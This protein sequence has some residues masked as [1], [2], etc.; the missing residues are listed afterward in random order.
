M[1]PYIALPIAAIALIAS[2]IIYFVLVRP[3]PSQTAKGVITSKSFQQERDMSRVMVGPRRESAT[4]IRRT[5]PAGYVFAIRL[6]NG[7]GDIRHFLPRS[8]GNEF[9]I[10]QRVSVTYDERGLRP[11]WTKRFARSVTS[12]P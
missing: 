9:Q 4:T 8:T 5:S 11:F 1:S 3:V 7:G 6:D 10:G 2:G 12:I